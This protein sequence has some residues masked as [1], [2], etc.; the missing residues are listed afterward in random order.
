MLR[1]SGGEK[2]GLAQQSFKSAES[3]LFGS[4]LPE[5]S[6]SQR[7]EPREQRSTPCPFQENCP[8]Q[9]NHACQEKSNQTQS[10][11]QRRRCREMARTTRK[12]T[13]RRRNLPQNCN[14][15]SKVHYIQ[16]SQVIDSYTYYG[17]TSSAER[18]RNSHTMQ[19]SAIYC[20]TTP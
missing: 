17:D 4:G 3:T 16:K 2:C 20:K 9:E 1:P 7:I 10:P 11:R 5:L 18:A 12:V 15:Y 13:R 8:C 19:F 14:N 6:L